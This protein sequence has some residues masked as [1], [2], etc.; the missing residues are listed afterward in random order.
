MAS[1]PPPKKCP[2]LPD[3]RVLTAA[4]VGMDK[5]RFSSMIIKDHQVICALGSDCKIHPGAVSVNESIYRCMNCALKFHSCITCSR[6]RFAD[7]LFGAAAGG[8]FSTS[9]LSE[10]GQEKLNH[11]KDRGSCPSSRQF[12]F[13]QKIPAGTLSLKSGNL[14]W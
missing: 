8:E 4:F 12:F 10:Y 6:V 11:Y 7:W 2:V 14:G 9:M 1:I 13:F 3:G 5:E